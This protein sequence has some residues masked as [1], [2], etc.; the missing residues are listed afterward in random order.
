[1]STSFYIS[2]DRAISFA[3]TSDN[4]L[5]VP[6]FYSRS[7]LV[8]DKWQ[9]VE[10]VKSDTHLIIGKHSFLPTFNLE[11]FPFV[12]QFTDNTYDIVNVKNGFRSTLINATAGH[13]TKHNK[14]SFSFFVEQTNGLTELHVCS[15]QRNEANTLWENSWLCLDLNKDFTSILT[16]YGRLP[17]ASLQGVMDL[18][19]END[20]FHDLKKKCGF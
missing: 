7:I 10:E 3:E 1:M 9:L 12:L 11:T 15:R 2:E 8:L 4:K 6:L 5:I 20:K 16:K 17:H 18:M 14:Q 19:D 13:Y